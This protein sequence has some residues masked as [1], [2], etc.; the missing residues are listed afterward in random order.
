MAIFCVVETAQSPA[1]A[2]IR[3]VF[4]NS[5]KSKAE[6][7]ANHGDDKGGGGREETDRFRAA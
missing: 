1:L 2:S 7:A 4:N 5:G 3:H 6:G